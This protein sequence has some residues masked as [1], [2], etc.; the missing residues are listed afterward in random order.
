MVS[1]GL[2]KSYFQC[3]VSYQYMAPIIGYTRTKILVAARASEQ[4]YDEYRSVS[5]VDLK[6][7][8]KADH[9]QTKT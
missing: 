9:Y 2:H 1:Q 6:D 5:Q 4:W 7:M 8:C 3:A